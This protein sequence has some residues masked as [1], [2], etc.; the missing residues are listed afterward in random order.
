MQ[1]SNLYWVADLT[2]TE[3]KEKTNCL[4]SANQ[5]RKC[6]FCMIAFLPFRFAF[7]NLQ[8]IVQTFVTEAKRSETK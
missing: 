4:T 5:T 6:F 7:Q 2:K 3:K 8:L 1:I